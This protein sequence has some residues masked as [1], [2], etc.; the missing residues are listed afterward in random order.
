MTPIK[1]KYLTFLFILVTIFTVKAQKPTSLL[2][3]ITGNGLE[4][5]SYLYGTMH[6]SN[7]VAFNLGD[8]FYIALNN[9]DVVALESNPGTWM[10]NMFD[11]DYSPAINGFKKYL[12]FGVGLNYY[13]YLANFAAP[14]KKD[15]IQ[16]LR[17]THSLQNGFLYRGSEYNEEYE[18]N[19]YLDLFIYQYARKNKKPVAS[20]EVFEETNELQV[21]AMIPD[22]ISDEEK[23]KRES[24]SYYSNW[25]SE[26]S[27]GEALEDAYRK[28]NIDIIDSITRITAYSDNYIK[29]FLHERNRN[30]ARRMDSIMQDQSLFAGIG[31]AHLPGDS[32][33]IQMLT[34]MGYSMRPVKRKIGD[35]AREAK[36]DI[37][38]TFVPV[39]LKKVSTNDGYIHLKVPGDLFETPGDKDALE[40]FYPEMANGGYY[41]ISRYFTYAPFNEMTQEKW[42]LKIDSLLFENIE[43]KIIEETETTVSGHPA[44]DVL[45]KTRKGD[46][47]RRLLVFT[48]LEII[49]FKM[50]GTGEWVRNYGD[51][52]FDSIQIGHEEKPTQFENYNG[53]FS[54]EFPST[55]I[56]NIHAKKISEGMKVTAQDIAEDSTYLIFFND[57]M[58]DLRYIE[59]DTFELAHI[60]RTF[61]ESFED[62]INFS[63]SVDE[64]WPKSAEGKATW[65]GKSL[66]TKTILAANNYFLLVGWGENKTI[67]EFFTSFKY[68]GVTP[69]KAASWY[70]DTLLRYHVNTSVHPP[71]LE[72]LYD[73]VRYLRYNEDKEDW[74]YIR[75]DRVYYNKEHRAYISVDYLKHSDY[76]HKETLNE[77]WKDEF[78]DFY[79]GGLLELES[80]E[81]NNDT[82]PF[83]RILFGDTGSTMVIDIKKIINE[84]EVY[85]LSTT[86]DSLAGPSQFAS[87]FYD[88]FSPFRD[89]LVGKKITESNAPLFFAD[90]RSGDS[91]RIEK[92]IDLLDRV[93]FK[94]EHLDSVYWYYEHFDWPKD[95]EVEAKE[96]IIKE[97]G[98]LKDEIII[99]F[100]LKQFNRTEEADIQFAVLKSLTRIPTKKAYKV[101]ED[102]LVNQPPI[103]KYSR[104][105]QNFFYYLDDS[106]KLSSRIFPDAWDLLLYSEYREAVYEMGSSLL[107]SNLIKYKRYKKKKPLILREAKAEVES[108]KYRYDR[109]MDFEIEDYKYKFGNKITYEVNIASQFDLFTYLNLLL[110]YYNSDNDVQKFV[111]RTFQEGE[112]KA[113]M[114]TAIGCAK[115]DI[116]VPD[117]IVERLSADEQ[118]CFAYYTGLRQLN[119]LNYFDNKEISQAKFMAALIYMES[120]YI[121]VGEDSLELVRSIEFKDSKASGLLYFYKSKKTNENGY[122]LHYSGLQPKDTSEISIHLK[123]EFRDDRISYYTEKELE[124]EIRK[125]LKFLHLRNRKRAYRAD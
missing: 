19:T 23:E 94:K 57:F 41:F 87:T 103:A 34:Q 60:I 5:P 68:K 120:S 46:Y 52:F 51:E 25:N 71:K 91:I 80:T 85:T 17:N 20:L 92:A 29:Y 119:K 6:V 101:L 110:P 55:P 39:T 31:A 22:D 10:K 117:S 61:Y 107:D 27:I 111:T 35:F 78:E 54:I 97:L 16:A 36:E 76:Y 13:E 70:T 33:V 63:I 109:S 26:M 21:K 4:E 72:Q 50:G 106:V 124:E 2:W 44:L 7:K 122:Y 8:T 28:G 98:E 79:K 93:V 14:D 32:G 104:T 47:V 123:K 108:S 89:S 115:Y 24:R 67:N 45:N 100:L 30:M 43:G 64:T 11:T 48:P 86:Y 73:K 88:T 84:G 90:L 62:S 75:E 77:I 118:H 40:Y 96:T 114:I 38:E 99:D 58:N 69:S 1:T 82:L 121:D 53:E 15:L 105:V 116:S 37:E 42:Q 113:K 95:K 12:E 83:K 81:N 56:H 18:E 74:D 66:H 3:E 102:L 49:F 9:V 125:I 112:Y 59:E 65:K